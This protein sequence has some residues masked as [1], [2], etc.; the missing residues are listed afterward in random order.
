ME[1]ALS[2]AARVLERAPEELIRM[3]RPGL[4]TAALNTLETAQQG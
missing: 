4:L 3:I 1:V 2:A